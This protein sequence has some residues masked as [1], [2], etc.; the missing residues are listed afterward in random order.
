[1]KKIE[2]RTL[3][4]AERLE[5]IK[6]HLYALMNDGVYMPEALTQVETAI[7]REAK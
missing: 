3:S 5:A 1:M 4:H 2:E 7:K 6:R